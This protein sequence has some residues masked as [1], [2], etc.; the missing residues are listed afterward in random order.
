MQKEL[1]Q[2]MT[3]SVKWS[4]LAEIIARLTAPVTNAILARLLMPNA[5]GIVASLTMIIS[6]SE[7]FTDAGFPKYIVQHT[8]Q[9]DDDLECSTST[10]LWTNLAFSI[11][12]WGLIALFVSPISAAAGASGHEQAV[13]IMGLQ[14]PLLAISGIYTARFRRDFDFQ[15]LFIVRSITAF[16]PLFITVPLA[17]HFRSYWALVAGTLTR[18]ALNAI[19]LCLRSPWKP[20]LQYS[21]AKLKEMLSFSL[22]TVAENVTIWLTTYADLW[23]ISAAFSSFYLGLYKTSMA[24]VQSLMGMITAAAM[25]VLFAALSRCQ[26]DDKAFQ[27]VFY[28]F[29]RMISLIVFPLGFGIYVFRDLTAAILLGPQWMETA[30]FLGMWALTSA[31]AIIFSHCN[32]EIFRS[33]GRPRLSVLVQLLHLVVLIPLMLL[34]MKSDYQKVTLARC[35][36]R[37]ELILV[38]SLTAHFAFGM[39]FRNALR[40]V[41]PQLASAVV[42]ALAGWLLRSAVTDWLGEFAVI[43]ACCAVYALCMLLIPA[44]RKQLQEIGF[45][46]KR[47]RMER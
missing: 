14:I 34:M 10:A 20:R 21:Y 2:K 45:F 32:S 38:S 6:F 30:D 28:R 4:G 40:N 24:T 16:V 39:R 5:F 25:P 47:L 46:Q 37:F 13:I 27:A 11:F 43:L 23:I 33:K 8:F 36:I 15:S 35:L 19:V 29:Q 3:Q 17:L 18:D 42:M 26:Q 7:I 9:D 1:Q 44:G 12:F 31:A 22:W 41:W